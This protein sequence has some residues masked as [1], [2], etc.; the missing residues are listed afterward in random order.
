LLTEN[1]RGTLR[2]TEMLLVL[3]H[4][5]GRIQYE[6]APLS[7]VK[8]N[9]TDMWNEIESLL[10]QQLTVEEIFYFAFF[11]HLVFVN[12][13]PISNGNGRISRLLEKWFLAE[14]LGERVWFIQSEK[15]YYK[16]VNDYY[17]NLA[18]LGLFYEALDYE[19]SVPFLLMLPQSLI[20]EK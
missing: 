3:E 11:I 5:T 13:H 12:I 7:M 18:R 6:A 1:Q 19:K 4:K 8:E 20:F 10:K 9:F 17:E 2:R 16:H 15:F 14:K